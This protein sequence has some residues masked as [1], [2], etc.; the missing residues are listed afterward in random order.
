MA[1]PRLAKGGGVLPDMA[2]VSSKSLTLKGGRSFTLACLNF[3]GVRVY[4]NKLNI[5]LNVKSL[6]D[7][8]TRE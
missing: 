8:A 5:H 2:F 3:D 4:L 1:C 6:R 7:V